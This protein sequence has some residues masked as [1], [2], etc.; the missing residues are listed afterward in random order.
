MI[1]FYGDEC[2]ELGPE[3]ED[4][5]GPLLGVVNYTTSCIGASFDLSGSVPDS[6]RLDFRVVIM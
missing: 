3:G 2:A 1:H 4:E 6:I 5:G